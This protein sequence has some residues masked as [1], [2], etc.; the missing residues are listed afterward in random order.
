MTIRVPHVIVACC[1]LATAASLGGAQAPSREDSVA[2]FKQSLTDSMAKIRKYEWIETTTIALKGER[3]SVPGAT[4]RSKPRWM[5]RH[6]WR[7]SDTEPKPWTPT[8]PKPR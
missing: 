4:N 5:V 2:A 8:L 1:S 7:V 6:S 3:T